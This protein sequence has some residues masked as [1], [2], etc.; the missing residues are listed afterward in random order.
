MYDMSCIHADDIGRN[1][2][3]AVVTRPLVMEPCS[4]FYWDPVLV[5][6][7]KGAPVEG[8]ML[9]GSNLNRLKASHFLVVT[10]YSSTK[11]TNDQH[12]PRT[13]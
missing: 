4:G 10:P 13:K 3:S 2:A 7:F 8:R 9:W 12:I 1:N 6:D 5:L 11:S